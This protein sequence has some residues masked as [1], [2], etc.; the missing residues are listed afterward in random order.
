MSFGSWLQAELNK[1]G[2][3]QWELSR[4][5]EI[6]QSQISKIINGSRHPGP[7]PCIAI[8]EALGVSRDEVFRARGWL[9]S[10]TEEDARLKLSSEVTKLG[11]KLDRLSSESRQVALL[12]ANTMADAL[13]KTEEG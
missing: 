8:A 7:E 2:W 4:Q 3:S 1:R 6:P 13:L 5:S 10:E 11:T 12:V 9:L